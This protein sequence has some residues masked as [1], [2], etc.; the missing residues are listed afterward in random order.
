MARK[1]HDCIGRALA[2]QIIEAGRLGSFEQIP[3]R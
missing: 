2:S 3:T 1:V